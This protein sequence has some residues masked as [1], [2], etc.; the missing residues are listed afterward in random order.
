MNPTSFQAGIESW[1]DFYLAVGSASAALLGLLFVGVSIN[2]ASIAAAE[3]A[4]LRTRANLAF[5]NLLYLLCL[6]L[7]VLI[8]GTDPMSLALSFTAVALVGLL[9]IGRAVVGLL[10]AKDGAWKHFSMIRRLSWTITADLVLLYV[11]EAVSSRGDAVPLYEATFV[12]FVLLVG[13]AD[14]SWG[15]LVLETEEDHRTG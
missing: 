1:H 6:S 10:R 7:I 11:A 15:L 13:A 4:D 8:P 9:R 3:R 2:L 5:S 12:V 14:V